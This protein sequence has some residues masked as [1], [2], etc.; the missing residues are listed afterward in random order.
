[1]TLSVEVETA[2]ASARWCC[3]SRRWR[4]AAPAGGV[5]G[6]SVLVLRDGRAQA[7]LRSVR[8]GL[9]TLGAVEVLDGLAEGDAGAAAAAAPTALQPG[10]RVRARGGHGPCAAAPPGAHRAIRCDARLAP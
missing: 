7:Q 4:C 6:P 10:Q 5:T 2:G 9:R 3:R 8:L 1:M